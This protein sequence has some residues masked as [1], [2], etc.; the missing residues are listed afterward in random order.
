M[1][2]N[3]RVRRIVDQGGFDKEEWS[4]R[5]EALLDL[6]EL[7]G[8]ASAD[9]DAEVAM[10]STLLEG[11]P[12]TS[13]VLFDSETW[14]CL[15]MPLAGAIRDVRSQLVKEGC[16]LLARIAETLNDSNGQPRSGMA[17]D[18]GRMLFRDVV[19][20]LFELLSSGNKVTAQYADHCVE[21]I[22][23][24]C[25][26]RHLITIV[27]EYSQRKNLMATARAC[28]ARYAGHIAS[29]WGPAYFDRH[30][31]L[32]TL[33]KVVL[34]LLDDP[35]PHVRSAARSAYHALA[36][37]WPDRA[38]AMLSQLD[39]RLAKLLV[40]DDKKT[41]PG[42]AAKQTT[43]KRRPATTRPAP[44]RH[45]PEETHDDDVSSKENHAPSHV[46]R[47]K[48]YQAGGAQQQRRNHDEVQEATTLLKVPPQK[49][50][51][52]SDIV[53]KKADLPMMLG[54]AIGDRVRVQRCKSG[55]VKYVGETEFSTGLWIG[56]E[57]DGPDGKHDGEVRDKRYFECRPRCGLFL[58]PAH[59][60][61]LGPDADAPE[62]PRATRVATEQKR[63]LGQLLDECHAQMAAFAKFEQADLTVE[64]AKDFL[65]TAK[66]SSDPVRAL[67]DDH[68][69]RLNAL[70]RK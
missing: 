59:V 31:G 12:G 50:S 23:E 45:I 68:A 62:L 22:L 42:G 38:D 49:S 28:V 32:P 4:Q 64:T 43:K 3:D 47:Q 19:P 60:A 69:N 58:R 20:T 27:A 53:I 24:K 48:K 39:K 14:R 2:L 46:H 25:R 21:I 41:T 11:R 1:A 67:V 37:N 51:S 9:R 55:T 15:R 61:K 18:G 16:G 6:D 10:R 57:L 56:V 35:N 30:D 26:F 70:L 44:Q 66:D 29:K 54:L 65:H 34:T 7:F 63:F 17:K 13:Q 36:A 8:K 52:S 5:S 40:D 33:E